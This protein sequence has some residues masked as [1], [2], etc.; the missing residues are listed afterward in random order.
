MIFVAVGT[1]FPFNRLI[2]VVDDWA[3]EHNKVAFS[4]I[5][6]GDYLPKNMEWERF[7][8]S[9]TYNNKIEQASLIISHAGMGNI[10]TA[11]EKKIPIIVMNRQHKLGE[12]RNDHQADGLTWMGKLTGVYAA[13]SNEE[14]L[15]YLNQHES[16]ERPE[17]SE[18]D[19]RNKLFQFINSCV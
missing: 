15:E 10:I 2:K 9:Q 14:L 8:D 17:F 7:I 12:H 5:A 1:Q 11:C 19:R 13:S 16:L 18:N 3:G 4:Q 6:E